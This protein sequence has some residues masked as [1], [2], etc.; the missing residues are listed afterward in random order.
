MTNCDW[1]NSKFEAFF[2]DTLTNEERQ[3]FQTHLETCEECSRQIASL[4]AID[5]LVRG[6]MRRRVALAQKAAQVE[7][8]PRV[9]K[10]ALGAVGLAAAGVLLVI[11]LRFIPEIP[12]PPIV[13]NPPEVQKSIEAEI[14]KDQTEQVGTRLLKP[15][16][17]TAAKPVPRPELDAP[18]VNG[19]EF[20][21]TDAAGY[22]ASLETFSGKMFLFSVVSSDQKASVNNFQQIYDAFQTSR[23]IRMLAVAHHRQD[24]FHGATFPIWFNNGSRLMGVEDGQFLLMDAGGKPIL[25]GSLSDPASI[26]SLRSQL[27]QLGIR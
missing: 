8:R 25:K 16:D 2:C 23:G 13:S 27:G 1:M 11:G 4:N 14:K 22:T 18:Q 3:R 10:I 7:T 26:V 12:A 19:P 24:D 21:I 5:P 15:G 17:G 20:A 9:L 6:V